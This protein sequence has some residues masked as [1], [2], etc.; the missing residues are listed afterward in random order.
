M[1]PKPK[2]WRGANGGSRE[3][4]VTFTGMDQFLVA[5]VLVFFFASLQADIATAGS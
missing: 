1:R 3:V 5:T 4:I 2:R